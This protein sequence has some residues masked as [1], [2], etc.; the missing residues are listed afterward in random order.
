MYER[1]LWGYEEALG[2]ENVENNRTALNTMLNKG[3][4][5]VEQGDLT[6]A[7]EA[8]SRGLLSFQNILE[9]SSDMYQ[10]SKAEIES[11]DL[12]LGKAN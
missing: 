12:S 4:F 7:R 11:L 1:A 8:Y 10:S 6:K 2:L 9:S 5:Y 3:C